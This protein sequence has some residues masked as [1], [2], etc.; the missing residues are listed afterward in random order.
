MLTVSELL[1]LAL[2]I[3]W[4]ARVSNRLEPSS[5]VSSWRPL[6]SKLATVG[7]KVMNFLVREIEPT[8]SRVRR[9]LR[10]FLVHHHELN[11]GNEADPAVSWNSWTGKFQSSGRTLE[12]CGWR[13]LTAKFIALAWDLLVAVPNPKIP[14]FAANSGIFWFGTKILAPDPLANHLLVGVL[15]P[16][17]WYCNGGVVGIFVCFTKINKFYY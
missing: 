2:E 4:N 13:I 5:N 17:A 10:I 8:N 1:N 7:H 11:R 12:F 6:P 16:E 9:E 15:N 14:E 3:K